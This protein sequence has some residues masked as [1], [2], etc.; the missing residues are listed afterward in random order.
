MYAIFA[1]IFVL[2][3]FAMFDGVLPEQDASSTSSAARGRAGFL[4]VDG[5]SLVTRIELARARG[6]ASSPDAPSW[7]AY[8]FDIR[9]GVAVDFDMRN[10][11]GVTT[12]DGLTIQENSKIETPNVGV[13]M[14]YE[15]GATHPSRVE[16]YNLDRKRTY[17]GHPVYWTGQ[18]D[19]G[20]SLTV[21]REL[22]A[23]NDDQEVTHHAVVAIGL[24][25]DPR[26]ADI[27]E[28]IILG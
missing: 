9:P 22:I 2:M 7:I 4:P 24:H 21:L 11:R 13:F 27:L 16:I 14:L 17:G 6:R 5:A 28:S 18:A 15:P 26:V 19:S 3:P 1:V 12:F 20:E 25:A 8:G 23:S 10:V